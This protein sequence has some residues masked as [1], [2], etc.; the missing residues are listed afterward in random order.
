VVKRIDHQ[1]HGQHQ[2]S[3][4]LTPWRDSVNRYCW[5]CAHS[6]DHDRFATD[7]CMVPVRP[8]DLCCQD[9]STIFSSVAKRV[10]SV[11]DGACSF[12]LRTRFCA[13]RGAKMAI[14][15]GA[16][17]YQILKRISPRGDPGLMDSSAYVGKSKLEALLGPRI[18]DKIADKVVIDFGCGVGAEAI[19]MAR[20]GARRVIGVDIQE[21]LLQSARTR[22]NADGVSERCAFALETNEKADVITALDSFEHFDNPSLILQRMSQLLKPIG[23]VLAAFGPT[24]YHPLGGHFC[25]VF[26]WAH[27]VFSEKALIRWRSDFKTDGAT[28]FREIDGGLNQ[29]T[30][31]Q[32]EKLIAQSPFRFA[33]FETVPIRKLK[34]IAIGLTREFTT[35]M[36]RCRLVL[37]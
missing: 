6:V 4:D 14:V 22:A 20:R 7:K 11:R 37:K 18:W 12:N 26:P 9:R 34:S 13:N 33:K 36:V 30:I 2:P 15:G 1:Q 23:C 19:E 21:S 31:K 3:D 27:L 8:A 29:M 25:S 5:T 10:D 35:S 17:G 28:S 16:V 32:F 24:W